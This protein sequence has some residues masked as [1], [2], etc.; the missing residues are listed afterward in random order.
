MVSELEK[1]VPTRIRS[2][3]DFIEFLRKSTPI[4]SKALG[5]LIEQIPISFPSGEKRIADVF[6]GDAV[7]VRYKN[8][9]GFNVLVMSAAIA[10]NPETLLIERNKQQ[11]F[12]TLFSIPVSEQEARDAY[13]GLSRI[14]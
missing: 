5:D 8:N 7:L 1:A 13:D 14:Q 4:K 9:D 2:E 6:Q 3:T 12:Y 11:E 10:K